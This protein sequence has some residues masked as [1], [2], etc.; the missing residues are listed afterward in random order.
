MSKFDR[1]VG[2]RR[3]HQEKSAR[4][5]LT[6]NGFQIVKNNIREF[7]WL[8]RMAYRNANFLDRAKR[9]VDAKDLG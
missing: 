3:R 7:A 2:Y 8:V 6:S 9:G 1:A 5:L 4:A